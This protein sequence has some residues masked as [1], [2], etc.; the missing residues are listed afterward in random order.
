ML[1]TLSNKHEKMCI[2]L[3]FIVTIHHDA[4][5]SECQIN[6]ELNVS[7]DE[8]SEHVACTGGGGGYKKCMQHLVG[9]P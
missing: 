1:S 4:R 5:S 9:N 6:V 8:K 3:A 2:S 7:N